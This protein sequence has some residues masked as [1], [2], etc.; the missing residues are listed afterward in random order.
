[1]CMY[2][3]HDRAYVSGKDLSLIFLFQLIFLLTLIWV[4]NII[5]FFFPIVYSFVLFCQAT[6]KVAAVFIAPQHNVTKSVNGM[7]RVIKFSK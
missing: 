1:M 4:Q 2:A 3:F 7:A 6:S 5:M